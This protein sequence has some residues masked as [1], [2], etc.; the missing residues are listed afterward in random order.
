M[1][2]LKSAHLHF[3]LSYQHENKTVSTFTQENSIFQMIFKK[4]NCMSRKIILSNAQQFPRDL[5]KDTTS[6][7]TT[8]GE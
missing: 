1:T 7:D 8:S 3:H 6:L 5:T 4:R 2:T